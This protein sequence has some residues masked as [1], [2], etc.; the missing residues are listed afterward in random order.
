[1]EVSGR[2]LGRD[3]DEILCQPC[4]G[5]G[6]EVTAEGYCENCNEYFCSLCLKVHRKMAVTKNHVIKS[7]VDMPRTNIQ[8]DPCVEP[9][10]IHKTEIVKYYCHKHDSVGCGDCMVID[11]KACKVELV[12][13][14]SGNYGNS[15]EIET[16]KEKIE[17]MERRISSVKQDMKDNFNA[18]AD[19]KARIV[20]EIKLFRKELNTHL[21]QAEAELLSEVEQLNAKDVVVQKQG[22]KECDSMETVM[23][24][25]QQTI[26]QHEDKVNQLFVT[27]KL[28]KERLVTYKESVKRLSS[29]KSISRCT[30][31]PSKDIQ[32]LMVSQSPIGAISVVTEIC[33]DLKKK[34]I[35]DKK[36][37]FVRELNVRGENKS[38]CRITGMAMISSDEILLADY[39][40]NSLK[41]INVSENRITSRYSC[42]HGPFDVTTINIDNS[43]TTLPVPG[44]ILFM[45]KRGGLS[46]SHTI[47]VKQWCRG[48]DHHNGKIVVS[49][50]CYPAAVEV[51]NMKGEILHHADYPMS[52]NCTLYYLGYSNDGKSF[53]VSDNGGNTVWE[54]SADGQLKTKISENLKGPCGLAVTKDGTIVVCNRG[55]NDKLTLIFPDTRKLQYLFVKNVK[56]PEAVLICEDSSKMYISECNNMHIKVFD[57]K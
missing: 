21:D 47:K 51:L 49:F 28:A 41:I 20:K 27:A 56:N 35:V 48:I 18:A 29:E 38:G 3:K 8:S 5:E 17:E 54:L 33:A 25:F 16:I 19:M 43:A 36:A 13:D 42:A 55:D 53:F 2:R 11:H 23:K 52:V 15:G 37:Q 39:N 34:T 50:T 57:L 12:S 46:E 30:F 31:V 14:V 6:D 40:S 24:Q 32:A 45:N 7:K 1:M 44:K 10:D 22:L 4:H 26:D 9:C